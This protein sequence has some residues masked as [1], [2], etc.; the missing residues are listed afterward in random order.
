MTRTAVDIF[1]LSGR[2]ALITGASSGLGWRF[3]EVL[4]ANGASVALCARSADKLASLAHRI[5]QAGGTAVAIEMDVTDE[6]SVIEGFDRAT[7]ALG[8]PTILLNNAGMALQQTI[9]EH[10]LE[11]WRRVL[12]TDLDGVFLAGR[13]AARRMI[14]AG[15]SGTVVNVAS[16][17]GFGVSKTLAAYATAKAGVVQLT[18]AMALEWATSGIRVNAIAPGYILTEINRN[19]FETPQGEELIQTIPMKRIGDPSDLDGVLL[20]LAS[21]ASGFMTGETVV[22]DG[23]HLSPI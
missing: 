10:S 23:G 18:R 3:A 17:L 7:E 20:L 22:I 6:A 9:L 8:V 16:I 19:F 11:D 21:D 13:E 1:D 14:E 12:D 15:Q 2:V 5:E 4:A